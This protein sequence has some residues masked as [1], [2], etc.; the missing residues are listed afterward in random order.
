MKTDRNALI[1]LSAAIVMLAAGAHSL[2]PKAEA[3]EAAALDLIS[4][5]A[6]DVIEKEREIGKLKIAQVAEEAEAFFNVN[7]GVLERIAGMLIR[8]EDPGGHRDGSALE[9]SDMDAIL[10]KE[11]AD[12]AH[13]WS[14]G[15][16]GGG[17]ISLERIGVY[18]LY[19]AKAVA[20]VMYQEDGRQS[21]VQLVRYPLRLDAISTEW[22]NYGLRR[23]GG[24]WQLA[25]KL[26]PNYSRG[27]TWENE[28]MD[29][30]AYYDGYGIQK[31]YA[32]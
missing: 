25:C 10:P 21:M 18:S 24:G 30:G 12:T 1:A 14:E 15:P 27:W 4:V 6:F 13:G 31:G 28:Y 3:A 9:P 5:A 23:L 8:T 32:P 17:L 16:R 20:F 11:L 29:D 26:D 19:G 22:D 2:E 7:R